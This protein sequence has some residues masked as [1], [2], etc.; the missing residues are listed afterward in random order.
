MNKKIALIV[1]NADNPWFSVAIQDELGIMSIAASGPD[2]TM[3]F[4]QASCVL[5]HPLVLPLS[6][7]ET[8]L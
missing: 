2:L 7:P 8:S 1:T 6:G 4:H 5:G 3:V